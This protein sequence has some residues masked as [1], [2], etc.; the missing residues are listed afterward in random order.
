MVEPEEA[1]TQTG[2]RGLNQQSDA[3]VEEDLPR[4]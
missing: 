4:A 1:A 2:L 3:S